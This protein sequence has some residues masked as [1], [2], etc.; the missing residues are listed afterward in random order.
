MSENKSKY[1]HGTVKAVSDKL[2]VSR[3]V[4]S[5]V[6]KY[7]KGSRRKAEILQATAE[8]VNEVQTKEREARERLSA[9]MSQ[10]KA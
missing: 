6:L 2:G 1:P 4:V 8:Y 7:D 3:T 10:A 9:V 5:D